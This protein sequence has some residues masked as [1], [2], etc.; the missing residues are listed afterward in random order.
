MSE[1]DRARGGG[2]GFPA[3]GALTGSTGG[4]ADRVT[5]TARSGSHVIP[6]DIVS[7]MGQGNTNAGLKA[8]EKMF[9]TGPYGMALPRRRAEGGGIAPQTS[10]VPV[11][12]SD[13]E[14]VIPP[15]VVEEIGSGDIATGHDVIDAWIMDERQRAIE[16]L[17]ALPPPATD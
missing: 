4:R 10:D 9:K 16:T 12:L 6:S 17:K 15:E 13:G 1:G 7:H 11:M 2:I 14:F 8:L 5:A 3:I